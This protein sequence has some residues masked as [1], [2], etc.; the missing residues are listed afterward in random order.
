V[1]DTALAIGSPFGLEASVTSGIVS[2][3]GRDVGAQQFQRFIQTDAAIN[4]GNSGG[5]LLNQ[6]GE[7]IGMNTMIAT[8]SG[9]YQG[10]G[11][12]LP[13]NTAVNVYNSIIRT[14][15]VSRGSIGIKFKK[16]DQNQTLL[17]ALGIK[18]GVIVEDVMKNAPAERAGMKP[19]DIIIAFNGQPV[20]DG[21]DLVQKVSVSPIGSAATVTIDRGG[22]RMDLKLTIGDREEQLAAD[23]DPRYAKPKEDAAEPGGVTED[24][25]SR[26]KF[27]VSI[28]NLTEAEK[29]NATIE[30]KRGV[31]VTQV[32][33]NS[34][35]EDVGL[36]DRDIIVSIN[37]QP[38]STVEDIRR[39]Q[40]T[41]K[42]GDAVAFRVLRAA[43]V[44]GQRGAQS[45]KYTG[46]Y[47]TG[48]LP[49][50]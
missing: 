4:P 41:L 26:V 31:V 18:E 25:K 37:R 16:Y 21:D 42:P 29:E 9:G 43:P 19:E 24:T 49:T 10:I 38:V 36:Q 22:K 15:K 48:T 3:T 32:Q 33:E 11:F 46:F 8:Q 23:N 47:I 1:G 44:P 13:I 12:A 5:P 28:R 7:V 45:L 2:A 6:W 34:F 40:S 17:K 20:K 14:G 39:I 27:G 35:A 30:E 50:E